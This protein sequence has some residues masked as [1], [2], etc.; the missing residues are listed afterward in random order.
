[1]SP[2]P[3]F[4]VIHPGYSIGKYDIPVT[5]LRSRYRQDTFVQEVYGLFRD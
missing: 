1:M 2:R 5:D 3:R 4:K